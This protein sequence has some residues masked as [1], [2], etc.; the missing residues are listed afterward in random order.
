MAIYSLVFLSCFLHS[1]CVV[2]QNWGW[3]VGDGNLQ[4]PLRGTVAFPSIVMR[5]KGIIRMRFT[6]NEVWSPGAEGLP[7]TRGGKRITENRRNYFR[8][9]WIPGERCAL[10]LM[11]PLPDADHEFA[12]HRRSKSITALMLAEGRRTNLLQVHKLLAHEWRA[13]VLLLATREMS[14]ACIKGMQHN[15]SIVIQNTRNVLDRRMY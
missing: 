13:A 3:P 15:V 10:C 6:L 9:R 14:L 11:D 5:H 4:K 8:L 2:G 7:S 12:S 1:R